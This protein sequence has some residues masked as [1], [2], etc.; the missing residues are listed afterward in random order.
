MASSPSSPS[1]RYKRNVP[2]EI[3]EKID[4]FYTQEKLIFTLESQLNDL[5]AQ[6]HTLEQ[7]LRPYRIDTHSTSHNTVHTIPEQAGPIHGLPDEILS[8]IFETYTDDPSETRC[9]KLGILLLVCKRWHDLVMNSPLLWAHIEIDKD[10]EPF[11]F[12]GSPITAYVEACISRSQG[13]PL[14]MDLALQNCDSSAYIKAGL[15]DRAKAIVDENFHQEIHRQIYKN[16]WH[17]TS[18]RFVIQ[19]GRFFDSLFGDDGQHLRQCHR[20]VIRL[21]VHEEIART[22][23]ARMRSNMSNLTSLTLLD[24]PALWSTDDTLAQVNLPRVKYL[25]AKGRYF[26]IAY[27]T[28]LFSI[29]STK[30]EHFST[31]IDY[32]MTHLEDLSSFQGLR[33]LRLDCWRIAT[34]EDDA[35]TFSF[36]LP[37]LHEL[38]INGHF[39]HLRKLHFDFP[40]LNI[41]RVYVGDEHQRLPALSPECIEWRLRRPVSLQTQTYL[42]Q[43]FLLLSKKIRKIQIPKLQRGAVLEQVRQYRAKG[44]I[45]LLSRIIVAENDH[46]LEVIN[47]QNIV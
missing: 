10:C 31:T 27:P 6:H 21:P 15:F 19:F 2:D 16:A 14:D 38:S 47:V 23:W 45:P 26:T 44:A 11:E 30:L 25:E 39:T 46:E 40:A 12:G 20:L 1:R 5:K 33:S 4:L 42:I 29:S 28:K 34:E 37:H 13:I 3:S 36:H 7:D 8:Q 24:I 43:D 18:S 32:S 9:S 22:I 41:L 35:P 17:Y